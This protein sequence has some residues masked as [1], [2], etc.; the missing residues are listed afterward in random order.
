MQEFANKLLSIQQKVDK[1]IE[2][3]K[4]IEKHN[5]LLNSDLNELKEKN[6]I[7]ASNN[8]RLTEENKKI[9]IGNSI[10]GSQ[11]SSDVKLK[12]NEY[13]REIDKCIALLNE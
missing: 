4:S 13:L 1:L 8:K 9:K 6:N 7:F 11:N 2:N 3:S 10:K 12:I 5:K